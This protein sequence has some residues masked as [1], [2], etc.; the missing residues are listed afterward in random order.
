MA[1]IVGWSLE[2]FNNLEYI[3]FPIHGV[4]SHHIPAGCNQSRVLWARIIYDNMP[5]CPDF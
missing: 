5:E 4:S 1:R 3:N 2:K